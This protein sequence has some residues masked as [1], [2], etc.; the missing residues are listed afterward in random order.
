M[1]T[2]I[3]ASL[4]GALLAPAAAASQEA[5]RQRIDTTF[6]FDQNGVVD[7]GLVSGD[8]VVTGWSRPEVA[9]RASI[10]MGYFDY[11][12]SPSRIEVSARSRFNRMGR[13][14]IVISVPAG[15]EV[16]ASTV[17]GNVTMTGTAGPVQASTVSGDFTV[18]DVSG[19]LR[20]KS[21]S[22]DL[23]AEGIAGDLR[24]KTV[25]GNLHARGALTG[26]D[27]ES[28]SGDIAFSGNLSS[29]GTFAVHTH[30]GDARM[31]LPAN[32][33]ASL[34]L[35]TFSGNVN[36]AFPLTLEPGNAGGRR[37]RDIRTTINNGGAR[38][39]FST[40]SGNITIEK[41]APRP[42]KED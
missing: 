20:F 8:I 2:L 10:E 25:S 17:S 32:I 38:I 9:I 27:F 22:G 12:A 18:N 28:V 34:D 42:T 37:R 1:R 15:A 30:S 11:S 4:A 33:A 26:L 29:D 5:G 19:A 39:T 21:V 16:S 14:R 23:T 35:S 31:T 24:F 3:A 36:S 40:F 7:L 6:A 13:Q 41:G